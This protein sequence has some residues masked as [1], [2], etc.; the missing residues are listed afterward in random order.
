MKNIGTE[1]Q[2]LVI[3]LPEKTSI[4]N[5]LRIPTREVARYFANDSHPHQRTGRLKWAL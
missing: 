3:L 4:E 1:K 2:R 5:R